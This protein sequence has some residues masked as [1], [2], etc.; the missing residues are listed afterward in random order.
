MKK[1]IPAKTSTQRKYQN[2]G[3]GPSMETTTETE[4]GNTNYTKKHCIDFLH[5]ERIPFKT[6][7]LLRVGVSFHFRTACLSN[8]ESNFFSSRVDVLIVCYSTEE[9]FPS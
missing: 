4:S 7:A 1:F 5:V 8:V 3:E 6:K 9:R 2:V